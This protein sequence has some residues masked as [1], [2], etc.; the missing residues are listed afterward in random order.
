MKPRSPPTILKFF[1][2]SLIAA[3]AIIAFHVTFSLRPDYY[4]PTEE[5]LVVVFHNATKAQNVK[6]SKVHWCFF[7]N[8]MFKP[9]NILKNEFG[10]TDEVDPQSGDSWDLIF[11]G[12]PH[13]GIHP[14]ERF[15]WNMEYGLNAHL[16]QQGWENLQH[17]QVWFPC[18]GCSHSYCNKRELCY[19]TREID[20]SSCYVLPQD[21]HRLLE[22]M[23]MNDTGSNTTQQLWVVKEDS[24]EKHLHV[25]KG[26]H[27]IKS[28]DELPSVEDQINGTYLVQPLVRH[29]MLSGDYKRRHE[30]R[31][32]VSVTSTRPLRAYAYT[33]GMVG[34]FANAAVDDANPLAPCSIDMHGARTQRKLGCDIQ[35]EF[36]LTR[37]ANQIFEKLNLSLSDQS[38]FSEKINL[39]LAKILLNAQ[40]VIKNHI[41]NKGIAKSGATCFSF[42]RVDFAMTETLHP[43]IYEINEFPFANEKG[44]FGQIQEQAYR[45]LFRMIGL[46][47]RPMIASHR[48]K[49]EITNMGNWTPLVIDDVIYSRNI[50]G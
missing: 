38:S 28:P 33:A 27:F 41:V 24:P 12:Y 43:F 25:G 7:R 50:L 37:P 35:D 40:P 18:M 20:P 44:H 3:M 10:F 26:V 36:S 29:R 6:R 8:H 2:A 23:G 39:L 32:Y 21:Q 48:M 47:K 14:T 4:M 11:G 15:D 1:T 19:L 9:M 42:L 46:D 49:Y 16:S 17:H 30:L 31:M 22:A 34:R 5:Q 13:C 45:E